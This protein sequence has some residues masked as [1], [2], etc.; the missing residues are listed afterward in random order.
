M[1]APIQL[2]G[3]GHVDLGAELGLAEL[4]A[5]MAAVAMLPASWA[6][7]GWGVAMPLLLAA[8]GHNFWIDPP[9]DDGA[10]R[11][12]RIGSAGETTWPASALW[13]VLSTTAISV[14]SA[15]AMTWLDRSWAGALSAAACCAAS[16][17]AYP[18][19]VRE[20][21]QAGQ[22]PPAGWLLLVVCAGVAVA[23]GG[24]PPYLQVARAFATTLAMLCIATWALYASVG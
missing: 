12:L 21:T 13:T 10:W 14:A 1:T 19:F 16:C 11:Q 7:P 24:L 18:V 8:I 23:G 20:L 22:L 5:G 3:P 15:G 17:L 2:G 6:R 9:L 4:M